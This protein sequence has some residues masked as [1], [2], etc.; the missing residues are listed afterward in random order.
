MVKGKVASPKCL[1]YAATHIERLN[2][3]ISTFGLVKN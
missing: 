3:T 1:F 2:R